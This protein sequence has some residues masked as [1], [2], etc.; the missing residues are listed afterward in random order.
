[1]YKFV[2]QYIYINID[3]FMKYLI[4]I[5]AV[6]IITSSCNENSSAI[7]KK[8]IYD[9]SIKKSIGS[10]DTT[11]HAIKAGAAG[12]PSDSLNPSIT[13]ADLWRISGFTN[14]DDFKN[15][16]LAF[17]KWVADENKDSI[18]SHIKFPLRNCSSADRFLKNYSS[19]FNDKVK[20]A[21][22][23]QN[24]DKFFTSYDGAMVGK[25]ELWFSQS[26]NNYYVIAIKPNAK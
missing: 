25:G 3:S 14:P 20:H 11:R 7:K 26:G 23:V 24:P 8:G 2:K 12:L 9:D 18:V 21:V 15:F 22:A 10:V 6:C 19:F 4:P 17:K 13:T 1:M 5:V 16:F